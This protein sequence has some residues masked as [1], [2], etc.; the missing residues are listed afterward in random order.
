MWITKRQ[1]IKLRSRKYNDM[2]PHVF[3]KLLQL[4]PHVMKGISIPKHYDTSFFDDRYY[5]Q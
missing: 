2:K 4:L 1:R 3:D 5:E